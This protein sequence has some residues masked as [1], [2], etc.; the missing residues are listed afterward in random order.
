MDELLQEFISE[1]QETLEALAGEVVAWEADPADR[2]RLDAIFRF[3][4]TVKGSCGFLN[5]PR[6]ERLSH[7][8]EDVLSEIRAG[9]R[10]ADPATVSAVLGIMDRIA[11]L[12]EAV[13]IGAA[14]PQENDDYLIAALTGRLVA[15][16]VAGP[17]ENE[18]LTA[19]VAVARASGG[20]AAP[21]TI[22]LPLSLIDQ[23]MN[24][25]SDM[26]LARNELSR[27]LRE[28]SGD[29][30]LE[31]AFERL[32]TCVA[33]MRDAISKTRMQRVDRLFTAI[34]RMVRD[35][36]RDLGK[37]IDLSLEG[38]DVEMD[39]EMVEMVVDPL[40]HIVR[41]SIDHGIETPEKRR[42]LG[43]PEAGRLRLEARQSGNQIVIEISDDGHGIDTGRLVD[44]AIAAGRLTPEAAARMSEAEKLDLIFHPGLSTANQ[45][46][47]ISGRGVGMDV[48][49]ANV[50]RIG[51][52]IALDNRP[53]CGLTI[54]LRVPLTLTIIPGL[55]VRAGDL[56]FAIPR[57]AVVEILHDN[58]ETLNIAQ[59]GGA[60][61]ATIRSVRHSMID[62]EDV[63][64]MERVAQPGPRAVMVVRSATGVPF[65]MGV[66]AVE[67]HEELVIRPASP[68]VM[69][70][71]VYAGMTLP[72]NGKPMLLLDAA[73]L[74]NAARL[75]NIVDDHAARR[76]G[77]GEEAQG[78]V[79][80]VPA[81]RFEE[82][83][84]ERRLLK[85]SLIERVEDIDARLFGRSGGCGFVRLDGRL[86]P[87][88]NG[89]HAFSEEKVA[90]LRLRDGAREACY[91]VAAVLDIVEMPAVPDMVAMHGLLS[92][93]AVIDGEHLEVINPFA[94]FAALPDEP[95]AE[96]S[97]GRCLLADSEDGWTREILAPLL[98]QAGHEVVMGLPADEAVDPQDV[99]LFTGSDASQAG[100]LLGC[101]IVHL[102]ATPR[103]AG[104]QDS[105]IYRY[106][107]D[108]LMA[109]LSGSQR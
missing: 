22:R 24:G 93:V 53:G 105:S 88:A 4:H 92:G 26:V 21:R 20:Q 68:L 5:L 90:A 51:G 108:A 39:R 15:A 13:A 58:N 98:R 83:S 60:K 41:N 81:L 96:R 79:E 44:K 29:P 84:G 8:A 1:T 101:R 97:S 104:P 45:V 71:G 64:G 14:L 34:P 7:A 31:S 62:L 56:H 89:H 67:N 66:S 75:P 52:V 46:T 19:A 94:L 48:V 28:R 50:E 32:S 109:A 38:G 63:L 57:A 80:M 73:G 43:K 95:I 47:A 6:F 99:V 85:L 106:D 27:K 86:V 78:V 35:L 17:D 9:K 65:A 102:R 69:A 72:D 33:D 59:V 107:Q 42:A 23:L 30:E 16:E 3:F 25:V 100:E 40:T 49:R 77:E 37:R 74:A 87:V 55:I 103:P 61:I 11:E 91:P 12:A 36:G 76:A 18:S 82:Y 70:S 2:D 54:T 10:I